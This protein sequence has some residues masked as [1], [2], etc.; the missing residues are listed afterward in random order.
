MSV[1]QNCFIP[2][3]QIFNTNGKEK[4][5]IAFLRLYDGIGFSV[6]SLYIALLYFDVDRKNIIAELYFRPEPAFTIFNGPNF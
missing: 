2:R 6:L 5:A 1:E 4:I 3:R